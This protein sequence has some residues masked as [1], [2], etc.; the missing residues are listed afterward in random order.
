MI[1]LLIC[2]L[3]VT[4]AAAGEQPELV[5]RVG[6]ADGGSTAVCPQTVAGSDWL[7]L[8]AAAD[9]RQLTFEFEGETATLS[10]AAGSLAVR[11]GEAFDLTALFPDADGA[12]GYPVVLQLG[13][14]TRSVKI[15]RS[16]NIAALFL[17]SGSDGKDR[18][19]V[20]LSKDNKAENGGVVLLR[21]D[22]TVVY[23]GTM[24]NIKGRG[25]STWYYPKKPYQI[26]LNE[27]ADLIETGIPD[28]A[29]KTWVLLANYCD[30]TMLH[31]SVSFDIAA[32]LGLAY[33]PHFRQV[34]L[35]YDGEYRGTYLLCEKTEIGSGRVNIADLE[36]AYEKSNPEI[37]DFDSLPTAFGA[38]RYGNS[39]QYVSGLNS[40][41]DL[42][43]GYLLEI[44]YQNRA[45]AE[46]SWFSTT[47]GD[48]LTCKSPEY[49]SEAGMEYISDLYQ[50]FENA[51]YHGGTDPESGKAYTDLVDLDSL[52]RFY[53][54][55]ELS[56]DVD[57][58]KSSCY[59]Y[60]P[61]GEEKFYAGPV[62]D[63]DSGY[64]SS[65]IDFRVNDFVASRS[66]LSNALLQI[67]SFRETVVSLCETEFLGIV[68]D[69][70]SVDGGELP[71]VYD[72]AAEIAASQRMNAVLWPE[73]ARKSYDEI[74]ESFRT[75]LN[76]RARWMNGA[77]A[78]ENTD[79]SQQ[80]RFVDV[81][82]D[83]WFY[84][85]VTYVTKKGLFSG[86]SD[87]N[88]SP[89]A[90][91]TRAMA[92]SVLY[93]A[94]GEPDAAGTASGFTDVPENAWFCQ[95]TLWA[96]E[97]EI[98][99]GY[100]DGEFRPDGKVT[101]QDFVTFLYRWAGSPAGDHTAAERFSDY[102]DVSAYARASVNWAVDAGLLEGNGSG[103]LL[104]KNLVTRA[105]AA[106][107]IRRF[108][109]S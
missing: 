99:Y 58:F 94:A 74:T 15:M 19:W 62:W 72:Y 14:K 36:K 102:A 7:F 17:T 50:Q 95:S 88:F 35:Y 42:S 81:R 12:D 101:R 73:Y 46:K 21:A 85:A 89:Q 84:D 45:A 11:N 37:S 31:N 69:M 71:T 105:E 48:Y 66:P 92:V 22:G 39:F 51:V 64:G 10:G 65:V 79:F 5:C 32:R 16:E 76:E 25:N 38:N 63:F 29:E 24:K 43:G 23:D 55:T 4:A 13:T 47:H 26:K 97:N 20:E 77:L 27:K 56:M 59:F 100:A 6:A 34:D 41:Q 83:Q 57:S 86:T 3:A 107:M 40:P 53:L 91:M 98:A 82:A 28:E 18:A 87:F 67:P 54:L 9:L 8:P 103:K 1:V 30:E 33:S 70:T 96:A 109:E 106:A 104:P 75:L 78:D 93:R 52:A 61:A 90:S 2:L 68:G 80:N 60:K 44:D 108:L 49:A